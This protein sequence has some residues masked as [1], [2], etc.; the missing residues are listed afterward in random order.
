MGAAYAIVCGNKS[1]YE[2]VKPIPGFKARHY[3][4]TVI[5]FMA[6]SIEI[7]GLI[8]R[9]ILHGADGIIV[10]EWFLRKRSITQQE[11]RLNKKSTPGKKGGRTNKKMEGI[12]FFFLWIPV[13]MQPSQVLFHHYYSAG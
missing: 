4:Q 5:C 1:R 8:L 7:N 9:R 11:G 10:P 6:G 3:N 12:G 2:W 13:S